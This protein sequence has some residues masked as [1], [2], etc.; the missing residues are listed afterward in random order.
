MYGLRAAGWTC[1][2]AIVISFIIGLIWLRGLGIVGSKEESLE[3]ATGDV[4]EEKGTEGEVNT[5]VDETRV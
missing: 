5:S 2:G 3:E 4:M 1:G